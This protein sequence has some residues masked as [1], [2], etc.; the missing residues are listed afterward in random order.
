MEVYLL[1]IDSPSRPDWLPDRQRMSNWQFRIA[2]GHD[3]VGDP[4]EPHLIRL[5]KPY[6]RLNDF[7]RTG[8]GGYGELTVSERVR[9]AVEEIEPNVHQFLPVTLEQRDGTPFPVRY[10]GWNIRNVVDSYLWGHRTFFN[11]V[12]ATKNDPHLEAESMMIIRP[13]R[14]EDLVLRKEAITGLQ[15]WRDRR[16]NSIFITGDALKVFRR[17]R[18]NSC[19]ATLASI[20]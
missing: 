15:I 1:E 19:R 7:I 5:K 13:A 17:N 4:G 8:S 20:R 18:V 10:W 2:L 12:Q 11:E 14:P 16:S 9:L 3:F 6:K